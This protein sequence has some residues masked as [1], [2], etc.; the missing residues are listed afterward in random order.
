MILEVH[1]VQYTGFISE[2]AMSGI[3][4][5]SD[6]FSFTSVNR[7]MG[8][9]I[10][11]KDEC[12]V[13]DNAGE[14]IIGGYID[15]ISAG[16]DGRI[17]I[18]GRDKAGDLIDS[19]PAGS[20]EYVGLTMREI[21]QSLCE[22]FG[23]IVTGEE[24]STISRFRYGLDETISGI[25]RE[26]V[27]RQG[28]LINSDGSGDLVIEE[29]GAT[30]APFVL[31]EGVNILGDSAVEV[32]GS[33]LHSSYTVL[34]QNID[35]NTVNSTIAGRADRYRPLTTHNTGNIQIADAQTSS[36]WLGR[37][38]DG[39]AQQYS[40]IIAGIQNVRPNTVI[41]C[42]SLSLG[43]SGDL[44]IKNVVWSDGASGA[45]TT[46]KLANPYAFG[47]DYTDNTYL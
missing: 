1:N 37:I 22:P 17:I 43:V 46:L 14:P 40:I 28:Y 24:G 38:S 19:T 34:G 44:L 42:D 35:N 20:G 31:E 27:T 33:M 41:E 8:G 36:A 29:A 21:I 10:S 32:N 5:L 9:G 2:L 12:R 16:L 26:L 30:R 23:I 11:V 47:L 39:M 13:L 25:I 15:K 3:D 6:S 18:S 45:R 7:W 4:T